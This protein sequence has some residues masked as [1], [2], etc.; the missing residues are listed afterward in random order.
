MNDNELCQLRTSRKVPLLHRLRLYVT[1]N[2]QLLLR[3]IMLHLYMY[4]SITWQGYGN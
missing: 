4:T 1:Y 3:A 2:P